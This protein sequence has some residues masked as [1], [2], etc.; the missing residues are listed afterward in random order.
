MPNNLLIIKDPLDEE[1]WKCHD[2]EGS[3]LDALMMVYPSFP[4]NARLY[5]D[6]VS[7]TTEVT[8]GT[9]YDIEALGQ[10]DGKFIVLEQ[11]QGFWAI[12]AVF[13][14]SL[15]LAFTFKPK[16]PNI[17]QRNTVASSPNNELSA[18]VNSA[19]PNGRIPDIFG[20]VRSTPDLISLPYSTF[21]DNI[22]IENS[23]M[24]IGRGSYSIHDVYDGDT[25]L[26]EILGS[27]VQVYRPHTDIYAGAPYMQVGDTIPEA[28]MN[29]MRSNSV[30]GQT[31]RATNAN[32]YVGNNDVWFH[33]PGV[34][35]FAKVHDVEE[36]FEV[37]D[38]II[39]SGAGARVITQ[40]LEFNNYPVDESNPAGA[41][42][43][44]GLLIQPHSPTSFVIMAPLDL[45]GINKI[46]IQT[47][48]FQDNLG[49][50]LELSGT[51][52]FVSQNTVSAVVPPVAGTWPND[53]PQIN[54]TNASNP[55]WEDV[56]AN[57]WHP[58]MPVKV[59][60]E[61]GLT[62]S[63]WDVSGT[64]TILDVTDSPLEPLQGN[65]VVMVEPKPGWAGIPEGGTGYTSP[66][67]TKV[68]ADIVG[69]FVL[70]FRNGDTV[71]AN[72]VGM[73]GIYKDDG[74]N[75]F[76]ESVV[77][78]LTI[79]PVDGLDEP[80]G[81]GVEYTYTLTG[82]GIK[83]DSVGLTAM[84]TV[85]TGRISVSA[86]RIS[87]TD[88]T[89]KGQVVDEIK[90]RDLYHGQVMVGPNFGNVTIL[91]SRTVATTGALSVKER[92]LNLEVTREIPI[93]NASGVFSSTLYPTNN[94][95]H[96]IC[97]VAH[98][99]FIGNR[100][101]AEL[102]YANIYA[103]AEEIESYFNTQEAVEF[104][105]TIDKPEMTFEETL[106]SIAQAVFCVAYRRGRVIRLSFEKRTDD[107]TLLFNHRN[108]I[109]GTEQR[110]VRFGND[111]DYDA[112][113]YKWVNPDDDAIETLIVGEVAPV[114]AR[115]IESIGVRNEK[116]AYFHAW[117]AW[118]KIRYQNMA[119]EFEATAQANLAVVNDRILV[120]DNTRSRS[121]DGDIET[122]N[123]LIVTTSQELDFSTGSSWTIFLQLYD[124]TVEAI[125]VFEIPG[126]KNQCLLEY[127]PALPLVTD[128]E[129]YSRTK[130]QLVNDGAV[131]RTAFLMTER[132][133]QSSNTSK[134]TAINYSSRYY[135]NDDY[136]TPALF[137][138][139]V[140][141]VGVD[142][143]G[144]DVVMTES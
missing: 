68:G 47:A 49:N 118:N 127:A 5:H 65:N 12:V 124:G 136:L 79:T 86:R 14:V 29:V 81:P 46:T 27:S 64:Y 133:N 104:C 108:K 71:I 138:V 83:R 95:A 59:T 105:Y 20:T 55:N 57:T 122:V 94:A 30:N 38:E 128:I 25:S 39:I 103:T 61:Y 33:A 32:A 16:I 130:Y 37:G 106:A 102:D 88:K 43:S 73:N 115:K 142:A 54:F 52:D 6:H 9:T 77:I 119:I 82:S 58:I 129:N 1:T 7:A 90:W 56:A 18:R 74:T 123:G 134:V 21:V 70:D 98:D 45:T 99:P 66:V 96:I 44:N 140:G 40:P 35:H 117:R 76:A 93:G 69:P 143:V 10:L 41:P 80:I 112:V 126:I 139:V 42:I 15:L 100:A 53:Y 144:I 31:L 28:P 51:M 67:I 50:T 17:A 19:R 116:Q 109:P 97:E 26:D 120:A 13:V 34:I 11:P 84:P 107:S 36:Y 72:F 114:N 78:G 62:D 63:V 87:L 85:G 3:V 132:E 23:V 137:K 121:Q 111:N 141:P 101:P 48:M 75:Q 60:F 8:P 22:E 113:E 110:T 89:F 2:F 125:P 4:P 131:N 92:K 91:R 24:C 135:E